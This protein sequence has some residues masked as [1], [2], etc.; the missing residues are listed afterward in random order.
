MP[1]FQC[2]I[3]SLTHEHTLSPRI[4][5]GHHRGVG[6]MPGAIGLNADGRKWGSPDS[7]LQ[8]CPKK[9]VFEDGYLEADITGVC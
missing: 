2:V 6:E 7:W 3:I 1:A 8:L 5:L 9:H 4:K